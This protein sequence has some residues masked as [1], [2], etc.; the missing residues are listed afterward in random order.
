MTGGTCQTRRLLAK[1][2]ASVIDWA[3]IGD[4]KPH[5]S[6]EPKA[7]EIRKVMFD[8]RYDHVFKR[9]HAP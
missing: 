2:R 8:V 4:Y 5:L 9:R 7:R 1:L 6:S 3:C